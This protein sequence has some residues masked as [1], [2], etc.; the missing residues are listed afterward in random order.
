MNVD[1]TTGLRKAIRKLE[2]DI[3]VAKV[4]KNTQE[5][6]VQT[7]TD[8]LSRQTSERKENDTPIVDLIIKT[9]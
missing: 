4:V 9:L 7:L 6:L 3:N 8:R 2:D 5:E 1:S